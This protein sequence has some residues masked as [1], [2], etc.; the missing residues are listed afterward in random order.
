MYLIPSLSAF[1]V[2][3]QKAYVVYEFLYLD[4]RVYI[5]MAVTF[6]QI[7]QNGQLISYGSQ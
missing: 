5:G 2:A 4:E 3:S 7:T 1:P 6:D